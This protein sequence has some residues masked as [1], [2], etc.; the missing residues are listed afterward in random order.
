MPLAVTS[1]VGASLNREYGLEQ[2]TAKAERPR[3]F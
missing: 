2:K 3:P 1:K